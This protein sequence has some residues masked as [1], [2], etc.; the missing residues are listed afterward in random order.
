MAA[1]GSGSELQRVHDHIANGA[2]LAAQRSVDELSRLQRLVRALVLDEVAHYC[3]E[4]RFPKNRD[5]P[6]QT[7]YLIDADGTRCAVAHVLELGGA[8]ALVA[9]L[10]ASRNNAWIRE[11]ADEPELV[12]WLEAVG[13]TVAEAAAIQPSYCPV[14]NSNCV[15]GGGF[16]GMVFEGSTGVLEV[17]VMQTSDK[18][19]DGSTRSAHVDA[20]YG[21]T[22][23]YVVGEEVRVWSSA[24]PGTKGLVG[25]TADV[26][27]PGDDAGDAGG[28]TRLPVMIPLTD[29]VL[30]T[31]SSNEFAQEHPLTSSEIA[32][33]WI[34]GPDACHAQL[35]ARDAEWRE[36]SCDE[37][38]CSTTK[39]APP[40]AELTLSILLALVGAIT[41]RRIAQRALR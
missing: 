6:V 29:G 38:G 39:E 3:R 28:P 21:D 15:C 36:D 37:G 22:R 10:A 12:A 25:L 7:P 4:R 24:E 30:G 27:V 19:P 17:T 26:L 13:L 14:P 16:R 40:A 20:V 23:G 33:Y 32:S 9:R 34:A 18:G 5:F 1:D 2:R 11:L 41:A 8:A 31:C 35:A